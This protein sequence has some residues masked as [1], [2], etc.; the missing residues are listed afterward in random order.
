MS[1]V[2]VL[3]SMTVAA[4]LTLALVHLLVWFQEKK[5]WGYLLF[6]L[7]AIG[8]S[9]IAA[10]ELW[11][12]RSQTT[13]QFGAALRWV[14]VPILLVMLALVGFVRVYLRAGRLWLG[15]IVC[16]TRVL[17]L[18]LNFYFTPNLN[19]REITAL[20]P[21]RFL[22]E[23]VSTAQGV[24]N[25]WMLLAQASLALFIV[26]LL[27]SMNT[28]WRRGERR[29]SLI[30]CGSMSLFVILGTVQGAMI[31]WGVAP[32]PLTV[33]IFYTGLVGA[34]GYELSRDVLH[35]A[36]LARDLGESEKRMK[37][38]VQSAD[39]G[40]WIW[41]IADGEVWATEKCR[42]LFGF[43]ADESLN[44]ETFN[45]RLHP[46]DR[47]STGL[48]VQQALSDHGMY[49][50]QYRVALPGGTERWLSAMGQGEYDAKGNPTRMLGVCVDISARRRS[51]LEAE[52]LR[53]TLAHASRVTMLGQLASALAHEL[54]QPLGAILRNAEAA[55]LFL[56]SS[57]PDIEEVLA[58]LADIRKDDQ[59]AGGVIERM[60]ALLKRGDLDAKPVDV[61]EMVEEVV[62]F[63]RADAV[64]RRVIIETRV[65]N[66]LPPVRGDP[67]QIQQV[68]LNLILN[69]MDALNGKTDGERRVAVHAEASGAGVIEIAVSDSGHGIP[70][71]KAGNLFDPFFTTKPHGLGIGLTISRTIIEAHGGKIAAE[72]HPQGGAKFRVTLPV[73]A[74]ERKS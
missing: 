9:G 61:A 68:L 63:V 10:C 58:I 66:A 47:A 5:A 19:F 32:M 64:A 26:F 45:A 39:L 14:H 17:T 22:G 50:T 1:W 21:I 72:N 44:Y 33:S 42:Q 37:L 55:E 8:T 59:R 53:Q 31:M 4:C 2:T 23:W 35:A 3:W 25:S 73:A 54:S 30:L 46:E 6:A 18:A 7:S 43:A 62:R 40:L 11:M 60:R 24:P 41:N 48:A 52:E 36:Q 57:S 13:A 16:M 12:M 74:N 56:Q 51:E 70:L 65:A 29:H 38:A 20:R 67:V 69:G 49:E 27:D 15:W 34:M 28:L 71:D